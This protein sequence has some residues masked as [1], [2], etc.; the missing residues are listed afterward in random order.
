MNSSY[1]YLK[2]Q[3]SYVKFEFNKITMIFFFCFSSFSR[4]TYS[5]L[6]DHS[7]G[8]ANQTDFFKHWL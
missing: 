7:L 4:N 6:T 3:T 2:L 8:K 5:H 1:Q